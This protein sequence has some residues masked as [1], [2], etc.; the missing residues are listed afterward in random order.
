MTLDFRKWAIG[1]TALVVLVWLFE[2]STQIDID[3]HVRTVQHFAQLREQ[4]ARL[5]RYVLQ[6]RYNLLHNYDPLVTTQLEVDRI[7]NALAS[8]KPDAFAAGASPIQTALA[9]YREILREKTA[10]VESFKS[11]NA[12]LGNSSRY[13]PMLASQL[14]ARWG[15]NSRAEPLLHDLLVSVLLFDQNSNAQTSGAV[16]RSVAALNASDIGKLPDVIGLLKHV[17]IIFTHKAEVDDF[18]RRITQSQTTDYA[19]KV[20]ALYNED[21]ARRDH[22]AANYKLA[23]ALLTVC[24]LAYVGWLFTHLQ[25]ARNTLADS[26]RELEFQ[27]NAL[28]VHSIVSV[29]DRTGKILYTNDKFSEISLYSREELLGQDHRLLNSGHHSPEFFRAMWATIGKGQIW[30]GEVLNRRKDGSLY[31]VDSTIA[32]FMDDKGRPLR[33]VSIRTDMTQRKQSEAAMLQAKTDAENARNVAEKERHAAELAAKIKG[34]FLANMSHE[35]RTPINGII[36]FTNLA[37][38]TPLNDDQREF[39]ELIKSSAS[40]LSTVIN[41]VL[42]F[43]KIESGKLGIEA[44]AFSLNA[45]MHDTVKTLAL[46][47][48]QK[49]LEL[50]LHVGPDVP[51]RVLGDPGRLR[52]V[53]VN[54]IGNSIKFTDVGEV[55][56]EVVRQDQTESSVQLLFVVRDT[57]IGIPEEKFRTI[58]ESFSQADTSTTRKYGGTGLGL[59]ISSQ[60]VELMGGRITV[61]STLGQGSNFSFTLNLPLIA[62]DEG[63]LPE[64][65][66]LVHRNGMHEPRQSLRLLLAEDNVTNQIL[67]VRLLEKL[68]HSITVA[69]NG[70]EA[71]MR[72]QTGSFD[73]ILMDIDMPEMGGHEAT[74]MIREQEQSTGTHIPIIAMTAHALK[75]TRE[76]CLLSGMDGYVAKPVDTELL[77][78]ELDQIAPAA[79]RLDDTPSVWVTVDFE[80]TRRTLDNNGE[81]F[82]ELVR[83]YCTDATLHFQRMEVALAKGDATELRRSAHALQGMAGVFGGARTVHWASEVE[84]TAGRPDCPPAVAELALAMDELAAALVAY[85]W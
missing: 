49:H 54:L 65:M 5:S 31:W 61:S 73:A 57:G 50:R 37:L 70:I 23:M 32:P 30:Q 34:D 16:V 69:N 25:L 55:V 46:R 84:R 27:K 12:V 2:Q 15:A 13:F 29:T 75:G 40:S 45:L 51:D 47:A 18:A 72:W 9:D 59:T 78:R 42:D 39:I 41:D 53:L 68:G 35:I 71:I 26:L 79:T 14:H 3:L 20:L 33:Y 80:K 24:M 22:L 76:E 44:I 43:S 8:D 58:F 48:K 19:D 62:T 17:D 74:R 82:A 67:A 83:Q 21:F 28:D 85:Q 1:L 77:W 66:P 64:S 11:H 81:L 7:L 6:S 10:M 63:G 4:D 56:V 52:Q 38:D 60:I 36:G